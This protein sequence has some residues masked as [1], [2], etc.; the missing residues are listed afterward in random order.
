MNVA[1]TASEMLEIY[2]TLI[3][4]ANTKQHLL[5]KFRKPILSALKKEQEE[6]EQEVYRS[7]AQQESK[8]IND[9]VQKEQNNWLNLSQN[10]QSSPQR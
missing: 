3:R 5:D 4:D 8:K 9:L 10:L 1:F 6:L 2:E 7:W